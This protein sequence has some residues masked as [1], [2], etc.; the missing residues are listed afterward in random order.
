MRVWR[1][2]EH[3]DLS[4]RGGLFAAA[5]WNHLGDQIVYC[6]DHPA[7]AMLEILVNTDPAELPDSY[8]L[9]EIT[10]PDSTTLERY[11]PGA[12]WLLDEILSRDFWRVF[13]GANQ[14]CILE[15]PSAIMPQCRNYLI[16]PTHPEA[17]S[18]RIA[19]SYRNPLDPRFR[20]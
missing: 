6:S 8:Q 17:D 9:L 2:S 1:I 16:N 10:V 4:G 7:T 18:I 14:A 5:R 19:A 13:I 11:E 3:A 15:V 12:D 20:R